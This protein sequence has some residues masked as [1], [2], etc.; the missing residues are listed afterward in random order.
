VELAIAISILLIGMVSVI[1]ATSQMHS[2]R[3]QNRERVLAQ[4][5][6]RSMAE[7]IQSRSFQL[8]QDD[9]ENWSENVLG[10]FGPGSAGE[11][12]DI[13]EL[14]RPEGAPSLATIQIITDETTTDADLLAAIGMP[15]DLNG[16]DDASDGDVAEDAVLLPVILTA[17]WRGVTGTQTYRHAFYVMGY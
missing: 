1:T 17:Q 12:F 14:N 3:R 16:D 7:R 4:N 11:Q 15:R 10:Q 6:L 9:P 8:A 13:R 5:G 2:L